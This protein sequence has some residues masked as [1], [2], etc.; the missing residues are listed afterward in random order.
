MLHGFCEVEDAF[1][2]ETGSMKLQFQLTIDPED[3][4]ERSVKHVGVVSQL[5]VEL[6]AAT[7]SG[8]RVTGFETT[9]WHPAFEVAV[10]VTLGFV[11]ENK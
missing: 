7:G 5:F 3:T 6:K 8:E 10:R 9:V 4:D 2:P 1:I 11:I